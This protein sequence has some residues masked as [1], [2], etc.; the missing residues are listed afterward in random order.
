MNKGSKN[1]KRI[2]IGYALSLLIV[3]YNSALVNPDAV[4][5][6]DLVKQTHNREVKYG[7]YTQT[8]AHISVDSVQK[9]INENKRGLHQYKSIINQALAREYEY[10][11]M[12]TVFYTV[13]ECSRLLQDVMRELYKRRVGVTGALATNA[14]QFMRYEYQSPR[15]RTFKEVNDFLKQAIKKDGIIFDVFDIDN[16]SVLIPA[17]LSLFGNV[18]QDVYSTWM[19]FNNAMQQCDQTVIRT[20]LKQLMTSYGYSD[21]Y[22]N[23]LLELQS[24]LVDQTG[25]PLADLLQIF[26]PESMVDTMGYLSWR[27]A[28]PYDDQL[29]DAILTSQAIS[30]TASREEFIKAVSNFNRLYKNGDTK[31]RAAVTELLKKIDDGSF[32]LEPYLYKYRTQP[33]TLPNLNYAQARLLVT[34]KLLLNPES[35]IKIYRYS[36]IDPAKEAAYKIELERILHQ[37]DIEKQAHDAIKG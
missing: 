3:N 17:D 25:K 8:Q 6:Q 30:K 13:Q 19:R 5:M 12:S 33:Q 4:V 24:Y 10:K 9:K 31:V 29:I 22:L 20:S 36:K 11:R 16:N 15:Y 32:K 37:M 27:L 21:V 23:K 35:G 34:N 28:I 26:V 7:G 18:G 1:M 2:I 14:F